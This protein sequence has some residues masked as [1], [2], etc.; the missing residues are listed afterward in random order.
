MSSYQEEE[1]CE[2][3]KMFEPVRNESLPGSRGTESKFSG[4]NVGTPKI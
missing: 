3:I 4:K 1:T 2:Q